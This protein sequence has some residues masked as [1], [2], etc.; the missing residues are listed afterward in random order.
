MMQ[1]DAQRLAALLNM[2]ELTVFVYD[3]LD[4]TNDECRRKL[5]AGE[6]PCLVLAEIQTSGK[7]RSG[8]SFY[9]PE[10]GLYMSLALPGDSEVV[11]IT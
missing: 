3:T 5:A 7:G 1:L 4:S 10:G 8:K 11:G 6:G 2:P 9:S